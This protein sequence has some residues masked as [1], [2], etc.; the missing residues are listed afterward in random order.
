MTPTDLPKETISVNESTLYDVCR[1]INSHLNQYLKEGWTIGGATA[2][3][4]SINL[5]HFSK[6]KENIV[7]AFDVSPSARC[8]EPDIM[9]FTMASMLMGRPQA[10]DTL[11]ELNDREVLKKS[12]AWHDKYD[13]YLAYI[14]MGLLLAIGLLLGKCSGKI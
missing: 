11:F 12:K 14:P 3:T 13:K 5:Y 10:Y 6:D 9:S 7:I 2:G 1:V 8:I 4:D